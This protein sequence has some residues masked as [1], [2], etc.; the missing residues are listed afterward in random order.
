M[1]VKL[2]ISS[3]IVI[4]SIVGAPIDTRADEGQV[5]QQVSANGLRN[6]RP[7]T[8]KDKWG[9]KWDSKGTLLTINIH[10]VDGELVSIAAMQQGT[11]SGRERGMDGYCRSVTMKW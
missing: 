8:V 1:L 10:S 7:F 11:G 6:L 4:S 3:F 5:I 2:M 9:I